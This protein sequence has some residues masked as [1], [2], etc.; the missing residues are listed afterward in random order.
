VTNDLHA[1][2][3]SLQR[4]QKRVGGSVNTGAHFDAWARAGLKLGTSFDYLIVATEGYHSA[5]S[6]TISVNSPARLGNTTEAEMTEA[7]MTEAVTTE[8][9]TTEIQTTEIQN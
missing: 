9:Q 5:G 1:S 6:A 7:E 3:S 8:A 2:D 4:Q